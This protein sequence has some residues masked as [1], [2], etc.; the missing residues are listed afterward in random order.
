MDQTGHDVVWI[1]SKHS[2]MR[3]RRV[4]NC[5]PFYLYL[6][7][8][9]A[10]THLHKQDAFIIYFIAYPDNWKYSNQLF[11][12]YIC[13][14]ESIV[15]SRGLQPAARMRH[16]G[17]FSAAREGYFTVYNALWILKLESLDIIT[18]GK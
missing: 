3:A 16:S 11:V 12:T 14:T 18:K 8:I 4:I 9:C 5:S 1:S 17:E 2:Q 13:W 6:A 15:K 7:L 10:N